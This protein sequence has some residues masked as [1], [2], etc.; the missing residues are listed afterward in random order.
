MAQ[1]INN[2]WDYIILRCNDTPFFKIIC[3]LFGL[4]I[5]LLILNII[6]I[7]RKGLPSLYSILITFIFQPFYYY[8]F[9]LC[10]LPFII[11]YITGRSTKKQIDPGDMFS[12]R[13]KLS[14]AQYLNFVNQ[15]LNLPNSIAGRRLIVNGPS[16]VKQSLMW[17]SFDAF[18]FKIS[19]FISIL[20]SP[21]FFYYWHLSYLTGELWNQYSLTLIFGSWAYGTG[22]GYLVKY[23]K[24][25]K[26][27]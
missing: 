1:F 5:V 12:K 15:V 18:L 19:P 24:A 14:D 27:Y 4:L 17:H 20:I 3:I 26:Y 7:R 16:N 2:V 9:L 22:I 21:G 6:S 13:I 10:T 8:G 23:Y 25:N 11:G